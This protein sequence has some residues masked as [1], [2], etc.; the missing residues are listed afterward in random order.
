MKKILILSLLSFFPLV[1][2]AQ[3]YT[4]SGYIS[5]AENNEKLI[6]ASVYVQGTTIGTI[7]NVYGFYSLTLPKG[8]YKIAASFVGY[9]TEINDIDLNSNLSLNIKLSSGNEL[10]EVD[11]VA[12]K[13][14]A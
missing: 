6:G 8:K 14:D 4:I 13:I 10:A 9:K 7:S 1:I 12:D 2:L 3:R 5:D 11:V